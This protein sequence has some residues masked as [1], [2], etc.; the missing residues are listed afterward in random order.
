[1]N[2]DADELDNAI[3]SFLNYYQVMHSFVNYVTITGIGNKSVIKN[4]VCQ[5]V[6]PGMIY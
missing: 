1:M 2:T 3:D 5:E 6:Y 4:Y